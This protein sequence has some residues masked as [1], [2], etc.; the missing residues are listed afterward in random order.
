MAHLNAIHA[1]KWEDPSQEN[2]LT[3]VIVLLEDAREVMKAGAR[4]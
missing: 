4:S 1:P 2:L 3:E